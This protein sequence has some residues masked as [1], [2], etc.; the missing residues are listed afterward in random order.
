MSDMSKRRSISFEV[1]TPFLI[2]SPQGGGAPVL[3]A[4]SLQ[5][6]LSA[7]CLVRH[8]LAC[9]LVELNELPRAVRLRIHSRDVFWVYA[10]M[11]AVITVPSPSFYTVSGRIVWN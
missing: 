8:S 1:A 2:C 9:C 7:R 4:A 11:L 10:A 5:A 6:S 3:F